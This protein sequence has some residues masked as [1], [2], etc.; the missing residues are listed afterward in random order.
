MPND[1]YAE[2]ENEEYITTPLHTVIAVVGAIVTFILLYW[3]A[4][5]IVEVLLVL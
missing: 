4:D 5:V 3:I 1:E 2:H